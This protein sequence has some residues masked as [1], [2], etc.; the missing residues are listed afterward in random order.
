M[1]RLGC[2]VY[3]AFLY[4]S[5]GKKGINQIATY[6]KSASFFITVLQPPV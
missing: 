5:E 1:V 2:V 6:N 4:L 3:G